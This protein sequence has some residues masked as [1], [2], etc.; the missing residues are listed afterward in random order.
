MS[1]RQRQCAYMRSL[2]VSTEVLV[3]YLAVAG[4]PVKDR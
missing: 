3:W 2:S 1:P 4:E